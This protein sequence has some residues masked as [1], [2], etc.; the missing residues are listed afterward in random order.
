MD[1][2]TRDTLIKSDFF[3]ISTAQSGQ[4]SGLCNFRRPISLIVSREQTI[5]I[6]KH[7]V[8][9]TLIKRRLAH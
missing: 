7:F 8:R 5:K 2:S 9:D 4:T 3:R 6:F 1:N